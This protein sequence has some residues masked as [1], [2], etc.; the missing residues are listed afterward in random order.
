[1]TIN[2]V[3]SRYSACI[4]GKNKYQNNNFGL[5]R[6]SLAEVNSALESWYRVDVGSFADVSEVLAT[7]IFRIEVAKVSECSRI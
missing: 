1:L 7:S 5:P 4:F 3:K 6:R 2:V